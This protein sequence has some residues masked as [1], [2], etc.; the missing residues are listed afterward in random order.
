MR[1]LHIYDTD[2]PCICGGQGLARPVMTWDKQPV[3]AKSYDLAKLANLNKGVR[4]RLGSIAARKAAQ[5]QYAAAVKDMLR[6]IRA[7][8]ARDVIPAYAARE[9]LVSDAVT[10]DAIADWFLALNGMRDRLTRAAILRIRSV[11]TGESERHTKRWNAVINAQIKVDLSNVVRQ[12]AL[13]N[14]LDAVAM[15]SAGLI[16]AVYDDT[17]RAVA[18][19]TQQA[20]LNG[21]PVN[22]LRKQIQERMQI[23]SK[24]AS[25]IARDQVA[26]L[27]S[28][29]NHIRQ[30]Q[31]GVLK[32]EWSTSGDSRVRDLHEE[33]DGNTYTWAKP[34]RDGH[35]GAAINC[36]CVAIGILEV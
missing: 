2:A 6:E 18:T 7:T 15:R 12:E 32:Y 28:E 27:T 10:V 25:L 24:R 3:A 26:T 19:L 31:A 33:F 34:P 11:I 9:A 14:Y 23:S 22:T 36:R 5:K 20:V 8:V 21:V 17:V 13:E 1:H 16:T 35:P 4:V 30:E 29:L